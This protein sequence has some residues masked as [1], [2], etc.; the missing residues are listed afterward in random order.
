MFRISAMRKRG[1]RAIRALVGAA[2][3]AAGLVTAAAAP[4]QAQ[5]TSEQQAIERVFTAERLDSTWFA[6]VLLA[7]MPIARWERLRTDMIERNGAFR[8]TVGEGARWRAVFDRAAVPTHVALDDRGRLTALLFD[9]PVAI[10]A[11]LPSAVAAF[12]ALPG[13]VGLLVRE[14]G[15]ERAARN[16]DLPL[17]AASA[18]KMLVLREVAAAVREGRLAWSTVVE[19]RPEWRAPS[20][21]LL[22]DWPAGTPVTIATLAALMMSISDNTAADALMAVVGRER[23]DAVAPDRER[24]LRTMR[25]WLMLRYGAASSLVER[26]RAA[27]GDGT[28]ALQERR[29]V[30]AELPPGLA[31]TFGA[32]RAEIDFDFSARELCGLIESVGDLP[33][34]RIN[35]GIAAGLGWDWVAH[36]DGRSATSESHAVLAGQADRRVCVAAVWNTA[37]GVERERFQILVRGLLAVLLAVGPATHD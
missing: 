33:A 35:P 16:P 23:L 30:L 9:R 20:V 7:E 36:K 11:D 28:D 21:G 26:W 17:G 27:G 34:T 18:A 6:P 31:V 14:N 1:R 13:K 32:G 8:G 12:D 2:A 10:F 5:P 37:E 4:V 29:Q 3:L 15:H 25:E 24:P 19:L 22:S